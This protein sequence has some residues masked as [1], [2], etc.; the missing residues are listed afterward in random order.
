MA[1]NGFFCAFIVGILVSI[2][3][4]IFIE[5]LA[6]LLGSTPTILPYTKEYL[7]IILIGAPFMMASLVLNNQLRFQGSASYAMIGIVS[8]AILNIFLDYLFI[9]CFNWG[10]SGAAIRS[11]ERRVGN[12]CRL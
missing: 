11:E 10:I 1:A 8:G 9:I 7:R 5:P 12:E 2:V 4:I 3:G 6:I